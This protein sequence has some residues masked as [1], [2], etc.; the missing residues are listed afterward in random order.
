MLNQLIIS[1]LNQSF[2]RYDGDGNYYDEL[3]DDTESFIPLG[4]DVECNEYYLLYP[5]ILVVFSLQDR[6]PFKCLE[7]YE[8]VDL[9]SLQMSY[10]QYQSACTHLFNDYL[11]KNNVMQQT[12][13][14]DGKEVNPEDLERMFDF[15][16]SEQK[17]RMK[18]YGF[19]G[20]SVK[21]GEVVGGGDMES[22]KTGSFD[23]GDARYSRAFEQ[24]EFGVDQIVNWLQFDKY[25]EISGKIASPDHMF[26]RVDKR[27]QEDEYLDQD[28]E[29]SSESEKPPKLSA[30]EIKLLCQELARQ[31][32]QFSLDGGR[33]P[34]DAH[35]N[36]KS[37]YVQQREI[38][39]QLYNS[40]SIL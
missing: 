14:N 35:L 25:A 7:R 1:A 24:F 33:E 30:Q 21:E 2:T 9:D 4:V 29:E 40:T 28:Y 11:E 13:D 3:K 26:K 27:R 16:S 34:V 38:T 37:I 31:K 15:Y 12:Y 22:F 39:L 36:S 5:D 20:Q 18:F 17:E 23:M 10:T 19:D 6:L 32:Q 8:P